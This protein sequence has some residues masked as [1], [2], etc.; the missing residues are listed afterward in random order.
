MKSDNKLLP[1]Q[2]YMLTTPEAAKYF[3]I[4]VK[5]LRRLAEDNEGKFAVMLYG[6]YLIVRPKFEEYLLEMAA[7]PKEED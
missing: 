2:K 1:G 4:G 6:K 5:N 7:Q 3:N